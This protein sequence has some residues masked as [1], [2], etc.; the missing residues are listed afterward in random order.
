MS[1]PYIG[2]G[3]DQLEKMPIAEEGMLIE[4]K[5]CG[6]DHPLKCGKDE[7]GDKS[8]LL[9]FYNCMDKIYLGALAGKFVFDVKP[10][11]SGGI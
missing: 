1:I 2:F 4:C 6:K 7:K 10:A 3:N 8:N 9:M 11:C 5:K